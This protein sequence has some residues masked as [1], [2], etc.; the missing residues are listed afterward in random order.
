V[1]LAPAAS[2]GKVAVAMPPVLDTLTPAILVVPLMNWA[3][4][5]RTSETTTP[6]AAAVPIFVTVIV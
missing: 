6:V 4:A 5:G 2:V 1:A 3:S